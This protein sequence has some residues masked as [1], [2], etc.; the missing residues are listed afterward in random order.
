MELDEEHTKIQAMDNRILWQKVFVDIVFKAA[1]Q[2]PRYWV[3]DGLDEA[4]K[5]EEVISFLGR[6][7]PNSGVR[8]IVASRMGIDIERELQKSK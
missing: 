2:R 5:P 7:P 8:V 3:I 6:I 4:E 1:D